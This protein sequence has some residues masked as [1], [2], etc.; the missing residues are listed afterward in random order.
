MGREVARILRLLLEKAYCPSQHYCEVGAVLVR[1]E[2][3]RGGTGAV[4]KASIFVE[5]LKSS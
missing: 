2:R 3:K 5:M 4:E 1:T